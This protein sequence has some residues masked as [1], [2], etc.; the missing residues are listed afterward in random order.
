[1]GEPDAGRPAHR[2]RREAPAPSARRAGHHAPSTHP[3]RLRRRARRH[4]R[5]H[6]PA[7]RPGP[8]RRA[9]AA[10]R[11]VRHQR[12][13]TRCLHRCIPAGDRVGRDPHR[14]AHRPD[15]QGQPDYRRLLADGGRLGD[16]GARSVR[17]VG[18]GR[19]GGVRIRIRGLRTPGPGLCG[20]SGRPALPGADGAVLG[21]DHPAQPAGR[22]TSRINGLRRG[23]ADRAVLVSSGHHRRSSRWPGFRCGGPSRAQRAPP[24]SPV[25]SGNAADAGPA[26]SKAG[27]GS[28]VGPARSRRTAPACRRG[29]RAA[30]R[31]RPPTTPGCRPGCPRR[32]GGG[33]RTCW[34][35][36][37]RFPT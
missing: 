24:A 32:E 20:H 9:P 34:G 13:R 22:T 25:W 5:G 21:D 11:R 28:R 17:D 27:T 15:G 14:R 31:D 26:R 6:L 16:H 10:R 7:A 33:R 19:S 3:R 8:H 29:C 36:A 2:G 23:R 18:G 35:G 30:D 12:G 4:F 37:S 1:M